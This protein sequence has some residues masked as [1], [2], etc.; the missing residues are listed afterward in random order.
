MHLRQPEQKVQQLRK[1]NERFCKAK[2]NDTQQAIPASWEMNDLQRNF[3][4]SLFEDTK[5]N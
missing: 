2:K 3:I 1:T 5:A 4:E